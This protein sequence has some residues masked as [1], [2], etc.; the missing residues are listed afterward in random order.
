MKPLIAVVFADKS[1]VLPPSRV[2]RT[3]PSQKL[4]LLE[5][6][7]TTHGLYGELPVTTMSSC[8][9]KSTD[10]LTVADT[11]Q[12]RRNVLPRRLECATSCGMLTGSSGFCEMSTNVTSLPIPTASWELVRDQVI[13]KFELRTSC[14]A[15]PGSHLP[16]TAWP[17]C[18]L[19]NDSQSPA[20]GVQ[21]SD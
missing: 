10:S 14:P 20:R 1:Q 15:P 16:F 8:P 7:G 13:P 5:L 19:Q 6:A 11:A 4:W 17:N 3:P 9:H 12:K 2:R 18:L 21:C